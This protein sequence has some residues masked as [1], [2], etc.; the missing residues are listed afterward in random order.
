MKENDYTECECF[1]WDITIARNNKIKAEDLK[2]IY[3]LKLGNF[4]DKNVS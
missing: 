3:Q 1:S 2:N 4:S